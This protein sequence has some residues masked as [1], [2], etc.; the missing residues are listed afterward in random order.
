MIFTTR[1]ITNASSDHHPKQ[2]PGILNII[3]PKHPNLPIC[4]IASTILLFHL[5][6]NPSL[7]FIAYMMFGIIITTIK[8][9]PNI[10]IHFILIIPHTF[11][12]QF[13]KLT[14]S[15]FIIIP[16]SEHKAFF[17]SNRSTFCTP[18]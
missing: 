16:F 18:I 10:F 12:F 8:S 7:H 9:N 2:V 14:V 17:F 5:F 1:Y 6:T 13:H 15:Y 3:N 11:F 4:S